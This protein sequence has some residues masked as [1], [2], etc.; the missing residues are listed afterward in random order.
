MSNTSASPR[1]DTGVV[2]ETGAIVSYN[3]VGKVYYGSEESV[4]ALDDIT[5]DIGE[6]EFVSIVGPSGCGKSTLLHLTTGI[7]D[8]TD[9][10]VEIMGRNVQSPDHKK[11]D[12][13]LVFQDSVLLEWRTVLKNVMLPIEIL[14]GNGQLDGSKSEYRERARELLQLVGLEGFEDAYPTELSGGM[15]QRASICRSLVYDPPVLLMDEPFG[16]LDALTRQELNTELLRIWSETDKTIL[17]VTH[18]LEEAVYLSD[19]VVVLS[20]R[21]GQIKDVVNV[22][23]PRPRDESIRTDD[24][25]HDTVEELMQYFQ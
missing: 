7:R 17:F 21:P 14:S 25:Y 9:G 4:V 23:L 3:G 1:R 5:F 8:P 24:E 18:N 15:Q 6:G 20:G 10:A 12:V 13:G 22:D 11:H 16:A 2:G 19:R